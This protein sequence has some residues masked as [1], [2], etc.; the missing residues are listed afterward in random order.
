[1]VPAAGCCVYFLVR[2]DVASSSIWE[3]VYR[4]GFVPLIPT[5]N[6]K[7]SLVLLYQRM[8]PVAVRE[9]N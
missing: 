5:L 7:I 9:S 8:F 2:V 3:S 4:H 1:M 6:P